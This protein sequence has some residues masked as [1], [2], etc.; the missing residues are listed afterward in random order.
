MQWQTGD[1]I[2][3]GVAFKDS[4]D[5]DAHHAFVGYAGYPFLD[6]GVA[7]VDDTIVTRL[8]RGFYV[9]VYGSATSTAAPNAT[10]C[11]TRR[12]CTRRTLRTSTSRATPPAE[13]RVR[14]RTTAFR[15]SQPVTSW[16]NSRTP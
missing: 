6:G 11:S 2:G 16:W 10:R 1:G 8:R 3:Y 7:G 9:S 14:T 12:G 15:V 4:L 13:T 5:P